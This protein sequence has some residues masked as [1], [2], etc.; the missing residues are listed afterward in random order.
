MGIRVLA[1][2]SAAGHVSGVWQNLYY[3]HDQSHRWRRN[4]LRAVV[5][6]LQIAYSRCA[7]VTT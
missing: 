3:E 4:A 7:P 2:H 6:S 5:Q 1:T